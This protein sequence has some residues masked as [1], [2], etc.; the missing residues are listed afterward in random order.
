MFYKFDQNELLW[1]KNYKKLSYSVI[2]FIIVLVSFFIIGRYV[3]FQSLEK[4][5]KELV[6]LNI[7]AEKK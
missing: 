2:V 4:Y 3:K 6:V 7:Q 1:K 5:E